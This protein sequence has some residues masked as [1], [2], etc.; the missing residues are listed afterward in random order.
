ML[1]VGLTHIQHS[2]GFAVEI[3]MN[4]LPALI[5]HV[6]STGLD[7][8]LNG[9]VLDA[10]AVVVAAVTYLEGLVSQEWLVGEELIV[11]RVLQVVQLVGL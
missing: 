7:N 11:K 5:V 6:E 10:T 3:H 1:V 2:I 9:S 8:T 4:G